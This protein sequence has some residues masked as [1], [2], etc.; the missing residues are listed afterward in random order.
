MSDRNRSQQLES[1]SALSAPLRTVLAILL[2][3]LGGFL[4][5]FLTSGNFSTVDAARSNRVPFLAMLGLISWFMGLLWYGRRQMGLRGGRPLYAGIGFAALVWIPFLVARLLVQITGFGRGS[6]V[7]QTFMYLLLFEALAAQLWAFGLVFR[8]L[9]EWRGPLTAAVGSGVLFGMLGFLMFRE[10]FVSIWAAVQ[11]FL[12]WG[13]V[14][15]VIR[16]RTGSIIGIVI[17]QAMHSFTAW[18]VFLPASQPVPG[19]LQNLYL[20]ASLVYLLVIW[21]LWPKEENDYRV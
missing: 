21:R 15:G 6:G 1:K 5:Q 2:P 7:G 19:Q 8:G 12:L 20:A 13:I 10:S 9:A 17:V 11:Y 14:Y 18:V 4:A 3:V 16:L